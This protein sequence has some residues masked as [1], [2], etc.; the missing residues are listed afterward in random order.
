MY[1]F[2]NGDSSFNTHLVD[3]MA[4]V[5][6]IPSLNGLYQVVLEAKDSELGSCMT[7]LAQGRSHLISGRTL[8]VRPGMI[9]T[10]CRGCQ[11]RCVFSKVCQM[12]Q[13]SSK[14]Y[15]FGRGLSWIFEVG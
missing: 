5:K 4:Q 9:R 13:T 12:K 1:L 15:M 6:D 14:K 2:S 8:K 11:G 3:L 10:S 7:C